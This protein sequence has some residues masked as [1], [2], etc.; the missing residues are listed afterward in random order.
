[1]L[2]GGGRYDGL[3]K[4]LGGPD[5][6]GFGWALGIERLMLLLGVE[7]AG[8]EAGTLATGVGTDVYLAHVGKQAAALGAPL[9]RDL[10]ARGLSVRFDPRPAK[11]GAQ[12]GKAAKAGARYALILGD[13]EIDRATYPLKDLLG[14]GQEPIAAKSHVELA[15]RVAERIE[16]SAAG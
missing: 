7:G 8:T 4:E 12:L 11:L 6:P 14:G 2:M 3:V 16:G 13:D 15:A 9:A 5:V 1:S 10:R